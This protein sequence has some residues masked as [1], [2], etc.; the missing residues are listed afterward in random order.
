[1][2][3]E[4][5]PE[6]AATGSVR[7]SMGSCARTRE[8]T[9][10]TV[11]ESTEEYFLSRKGGCYAS[12]YQALPAATGRRPESG[13]PFHTSRSRRALAPQSGGPS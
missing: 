7:T 6:P 8:L 3:E 10:S 4:Q 12:R 9:G 2:L 1:M 13:P 11:A 5:R